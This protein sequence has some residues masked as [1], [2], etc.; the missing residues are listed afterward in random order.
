MMKYNEAD[1]MMQYIL[2][3]DKRIRELKSTGATMQKLDVVVHLLI[4][5]SK[6]YDNLVTALETMDQSKLTVDFVKTRLMDEHN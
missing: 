5:M 1:D 2:Q 4:T 6:S 3:F